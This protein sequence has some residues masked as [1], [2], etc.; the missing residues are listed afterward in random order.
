MSADNNNQPASAEDRR[1]S[2][3]GPQY[4]VLAGKWSL[5]LF[6]EP[7]LRSP[8]PYSALSPQSSTL[9]LSY[10]A[11]RTQHCALRT[12]HCHYV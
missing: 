6:K 4:L 5:T 7:Y 8:R 9:R 3:G 10:L 12:E 11:L 2:N 1:P